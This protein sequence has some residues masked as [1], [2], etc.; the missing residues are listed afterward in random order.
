MPLATLKRMH[1]T[2]NCGDNAWEGSFAIVTWKLTGYHKIMFIMIPR[3][4]VPNTI[5]T[6][7]NKARYILNCFDNFFCLI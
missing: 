3:K 4:I 5:V 2:Q 7:I 6:N 1:I